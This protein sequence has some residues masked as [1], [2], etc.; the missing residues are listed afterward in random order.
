MRVDIV[1][2]HAHQRIDGF[3]HDLAL[4]L[5]QVLAEFSAD[6]RQLGIDGADLLAGLLILVDARA[7]IVAQCARKQELFALVQ[8]FGINGGQP[9][10]N[11]P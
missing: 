3:Q 4:N 2:R 7:T 5:A 1:L 10:I 6:F 11:R 8:R 9:L